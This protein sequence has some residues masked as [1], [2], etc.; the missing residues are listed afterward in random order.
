MGGAN[1][2][3]DSPVFG[4]AE[5]ISKRDVVKIPN[6]NI[7]RSISSNDG[8]DNHSK[9]RV[10]EI[11]NGSTVDDDDIEDIPETKHTPVFIKR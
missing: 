8:K 3:D 7:S 1:A 5:A 11:P 4:E 6:G 10:N 9:N 2:A